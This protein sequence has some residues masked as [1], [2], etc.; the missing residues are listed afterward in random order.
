MAGKLIELKFK[1]LKILLKKLDRLSRSGT[2]FPDA[3]KDELGHYV[4][5]RIQARTAEGKDANGKPFTP[6]DIAYARW[7]EQH[8]HP[9]KKVNL[10]L[11]GS[12]MASMTYETGPDFVR[13]FYPNT[14]DPKGVSNAAK[15]FWLSEDR[16]FH[17][18]SAQDKSGVQGIIDQFIAK[19]L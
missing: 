5:T 1:G 3:L 19:A 15:A 13:I 12:M 8:G 16:L 2:L 17:A 11:T 4:I 10:F 18:L 14:N 6:Y 7:R 9:A